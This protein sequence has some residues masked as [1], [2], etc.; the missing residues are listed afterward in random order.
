M[1]GQI[2]L[3]E[4][5]HLVVISEKMAVNE[6]TESRTQNYYRPIQAKYYYGS[7]FTCANYYT[8]SALC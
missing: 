4:A 6:S 2:I 1:N 5:H 3:F 7:I 8:V